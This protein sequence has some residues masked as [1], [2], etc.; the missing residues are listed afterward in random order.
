[1]KTHACYM[2]LVAH[3][4]GLCSTSALRAA[5]A[6]E[7]TDHLPAGTTKAINKHVRLLFE[8]KDARLYS[9]WIE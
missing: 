6:W 2:V 8:L 1:M 5:I 9:F 7:T 4:V 3:W